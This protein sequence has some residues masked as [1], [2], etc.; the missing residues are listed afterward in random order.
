MIIK[1][2]NLGKLEYL[3]HIIDVELIFCHIVDVELILAIFIEFLLGPVKNKLI[4]C[5][6][7]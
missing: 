4:V 1:S 3:C 5:P 7:I 2:G 6:I